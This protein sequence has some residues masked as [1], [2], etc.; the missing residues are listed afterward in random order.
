M[1]DVT[2]PPR[3]VAILQQARQM[4]NVPLVIPQLRSYC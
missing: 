3:H 1:Y 2:K 4:T